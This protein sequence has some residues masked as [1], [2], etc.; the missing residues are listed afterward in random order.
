MSLSIRL[1]EL[2][3]FDIPRGP[4]QITWVVARVTQHWTGMTHSADGSELAKLSITENYLPLF[5]FKEL[6][7]K[8]VSET[9]PLL[10]EKVAEFGTMPTDDPWG[11]TPGNVGAVLT[12]LRDWAKAHPCGIWTLRDTGW[13][14]TIRESQK[15]NSPVAFGV[16][17]Q[18]E[19]QEVV[20]MALGHGLMER[21]M[22]QARVLMAMRKKW[23]LCPPSELKDFFQKTLGDSNP[24]GG[25]LITK[26]A[27]LSFTLAVA[28]Q[29]LKNSSS[30]FTGEDLKDVLVE[31]LEPVRWSKKFRHDC[32]GCV[33]LGGND[34]YDFYICCP[35][36]EASILARCG[37]EGPNYESCPVEVAE[38]IER[39]DINSPLVKALQL[40][41]V[42]GY[43]K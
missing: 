18:A 2:V 26:R 42:Q 29:L 31:L 19:Q 32:D 17:N 24:G 34:E 22:L 12:T 30:G 33:F 9:L 8:I 15:D 35:K 37:D 28:D 10:E 13:A 43:V 11:C 4:R 7:G 41:R 16:Y 14:E 5:N 23:L 3:P 21:T 1:L 25:R 27:V 6:E 40:A 39:G 36:S 20:R 38:V